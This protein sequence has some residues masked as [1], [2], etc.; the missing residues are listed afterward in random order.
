MFGMLSVLAEL[1]RELII[2]NTRDGLAAAR[3][4]GRTGGRPPKLNPEQTALAQQ[5]Y[6]TGE[7]TVQQI[8]DLFNVPRTTVYGH[9]DSASKGTRAMS[10][11]G[12]APRLSGRIPFRCSSRAVTPPDGLDRRL[13]PL[14]RTTGPRIE[15]R[16]AAAASTHHARWRRPSL[17]TA[18]SAPAAD[19]AACTSSV[20]GE[21]VRLRR[22]VVRRCPKSALRSPPHFF[23]EGLRDWRALTMTSRETARRSH[24]VV[25]EP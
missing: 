14:T 4:R 16:G 23:G 12:R 21:Q 18:W 3:A 24:P 1:Q 20:G 6:D 9:L 8:A 7:R 15:S 5:L 10:Q 2:A 11:S 13:G 25:L 22:G 19:A 17:E